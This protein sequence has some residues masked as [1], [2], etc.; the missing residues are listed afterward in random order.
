MKQR[1]YSVYSRRDDMPIIIHGT[2]RECAEALG[3]TVN[4]FY[5]MVS[6]TRNR[7]PDASRRYFVYID[8][9]EEDD[10]DEMDLY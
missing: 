5:R 4:A 8:D 9:D 10:E 7:K 1:W 2:S 3:I 6:R